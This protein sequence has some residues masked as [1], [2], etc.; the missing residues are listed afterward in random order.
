MSKT[1]FLNAHSCRAETLKLFEKYNKQLL[2]EIRTE[3]DYQIPK[4]YISWQQLSAI[5]GLALSTCEVDYVKVD[6][7]AF[8][9]S[10]R[11]ALWFAQ[12]AP[13]YCLSN[14]LFEA[15]DNTNALDKPEVFAGWKP[16]LPSLVVAI[17]KGVLLSPTGEIDYIVIYC[18]E[19]SHPEWNF[20]R[21]KNVNI[22]NLTR[23]EVSF[24]WAAVDKG[25]TVWFSGTVVT[26][27]GDLIYDKQFLTNLGKNQIK[28][29]DRDFIERVR[30]LVINILLSL[31]FCPEFTGEVLDNE[32]VQPKGFG[33]VASDRSNI[34]RPRWLGK[35]YQRK[36]KGVG[37]STHLS[38][39]THW[40]KGHWRLLEPTP[41]KPWKQ[42]QLIWIEPVLV[43]G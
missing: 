42:S 26:P 1:V 17:P 25:E 23:K 31:E 3:R 13:L 4:G 32:V 8:Y 10:Y 16:S 20:S 22:P 39:H 14:S 7:S 21:W 24:E 12:D 36:H 15:L 9:H 18:S 6:I 2:K 43:N 34:R 28:N 30:N 37:E 27:Q 35:N 5:T 29:R 40:R 33:N 41:G 38:P 11:L 19:P